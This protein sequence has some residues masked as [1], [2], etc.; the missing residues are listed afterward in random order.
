MTVRPILIAA[1]LIAPALSAP[2]LAEPAA[3]GV[4]AEHGAL[5]GRSPHRAYRTAAPAR[6][7]APAMHSIPAGKPLVWGRHALA[8][9][10][11][12]TTDVTL[13]RAHA[14]Q[15]DTRR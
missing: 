8:D 5:S 11:C 14:A 3:T 12:A 2:A 9:G 13:A 7:C 15:P 1:A 10:R 6:D 4:H